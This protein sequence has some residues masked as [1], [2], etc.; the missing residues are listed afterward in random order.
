MH[1]LYHAS[2]ARIDLEQKPTDAIALRKTMSG[3]NAGEVD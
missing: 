3:G 2:A 1:N